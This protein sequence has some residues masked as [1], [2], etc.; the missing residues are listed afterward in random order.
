MKRS[1]DNIVKRYK[2]VFICTPLILVALIAPFLDTTYFVIF[3]MVM[4][5]LMISFDK[6]SD[7]D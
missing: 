3:A 6:I 1:K 5:M 2:P 7:R 4:L